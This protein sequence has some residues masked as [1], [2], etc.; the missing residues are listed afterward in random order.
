M[1]VCR[2]TRRKH[3]YQD[4]GWSAAGHSATRSASSISS[5]SSPYVLTAIKATCLCVESP[6]GVISP[7][8]HKLCSIKPSYFL[9]RHLVLRAPGNRN[10]ISLENNDSTD[11]FR[12]PNM[13]AC[14][15]PKNIKDQNPG[16]IRRCGL[17]R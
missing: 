17:S 2:S 4:P 13:A 11:L 9:D 5:S 16:H 3:G 10:R 14:L 7:V 1:C 6:Q 15:L 8:S 12:E